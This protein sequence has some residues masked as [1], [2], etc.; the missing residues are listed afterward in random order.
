MGGYKMTR[1]HV[2]KKRGTEE[3]VGQGE[4]AEVRSTMQV[5]NSQE[6]LGVSGKVC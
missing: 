6:A 3:K 1:Q 2:S 5:T 4:G